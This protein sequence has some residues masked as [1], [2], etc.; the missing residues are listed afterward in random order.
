MP[1]CINLLAEAKLAEE[2]R[3]KD[4][5]KRAVFIAGFIVFLFV[6]WTSTL[7]FK[8]IAS[9]SELNRLD[10]RWKE[11][12]KTYQG[13]IDT[14]KR[15]ADAEIKLTALQQLT[16]N[17]FLWGTALNAVQQTLGNIEN[18]HV[19]RLKTEQAYTLAEEQKARKDGTRLVGGRPAT[20]TERI[21]I[22]L[23][24][25]DASAQ[26]GASVSRFKESIAVVPFFQ[27]SLQKTN[28]VL[29]TSLSAPQTG[30]TG[31]QQVNFTVQCFF[32]EKVRP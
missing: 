18:V 29:L 3:R 30:P 31:R 4:P 13:A 11:I 24:A 17:R 19:T 2:L 7:Q 27:T 15:A 23:D 32:P 10:A 12:E 16:T 8:I 1:I 6:L 25:I 26:P 21:S 9:R 14:R 20:A 5:V 22:T 28:G